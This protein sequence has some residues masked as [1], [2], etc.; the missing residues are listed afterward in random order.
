MPTGHVPQCHISMVLEPSPW[1][2]CSNASSLFRRIMFSTFQPKP[3]LVQLEAITSVPFSG[4]ILGLNVFLVARGPKLNS[5]PEAQPHQHQTQKDDHFPGIMNVEFTPVFWCSF[6]AP[7]LQKTI[8][9]SNGSNGR[10][11][12][13]RD[14]VLMDPRVGFG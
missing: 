3:L 13:N 7:N 1:A 8:R 12:V 11:M 5:A 9:W 14:C 2:A 10:W 4:H 6:G